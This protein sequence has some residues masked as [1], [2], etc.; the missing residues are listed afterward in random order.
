MVVVGPPAMEASVVASGHRF[1]PGGEPAE[2]EIAAIREQLPVLPQGEAAVLG[3]RELFGRLA[4]QA[5]LPAMGRVFA[6]WRPEF[7]VREPCE[8]ASAV[9]AMATETPVVQV[10]IS[11]AQLESGALEIA[12][13][14]LEEHRPGLTDAI[15][16]TP[17]L[18]RFPGSLDPSPFP[19]TIRSRLAAHGPSDPLPDWWEGSRAPLVYVTFGTVLGHMSYAPGV[20]RTAIR[21]VT[22][23][24]AR[25]LVTIG[26]RLDPATLGAVPSHVHVEPWVDQSRVMGEAAVVVC[27]GG[28][29][30]VFGALEAGVPLV[31]VPVFADQFENGRRVA[32][33]GAGRHVLGPASG[34]GTGKRRP[35]GEEGA[36]LITDATKTVMGDDSYRSRARGIAAE[37]AEAA[38]TEDVLHSLA[39]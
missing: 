15:A 25:I 7:V 26:R 5:M 29:G 35:I 21:A 4:T 1:W 8:Y 24:E 22:E 34:G 23:L 37:M 27:H 10:A 11:L 38:R 33:A 18:T 9:L 32:A 12:R 6:D 13:D 30:T 39:P 19:T 16:S 2:E 14:A 36:H 3:N 31:T 28:S 20:F 17:Y